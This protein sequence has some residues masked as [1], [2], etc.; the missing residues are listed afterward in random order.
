MSW[1]D[2][3][4]VYQED[5][6]PIHE[7]AAVEPRLDFYALTRE[8]LAGALADRFEASAYR[9]TQL[10][11]WVYK[12][13]VIDCGQMT[14]ITK[15]LR[16]ELPGAFSFEPAVIKQKLV[17][18][19]GSRKYLLEVRPGVQVETVLI[20]QPERTTL[21]VSSQYG[22]G[23][24]C[25]FCRTGTMGFLANLTTGD[26]LRQVNAVRDDHPGQEQLFGNIVFMGMGEPLHNINAVAGAVRILKDCHA[27][28]VGPR[29]IT[30]STVGLVPGIRKFIAAD[31]EVNLAVS[32]NATTDE[33]RERIMPVTKRY[34]I[35]QL[36]ACLREV[37]LKKRRKIT[38]EYVMLSDVNDTD[39]D[40]RRLPGLL[41]GLSV[42][43]NLIPYN[44]NAGLPFKSP[45][46]S[47]VL[48]WHESLNLSGLDTTVRWSR[49]LDINAACGQLAVKES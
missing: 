30:V 45:P 13:R 4:A 8:E 5:Q 28:G 24:A 27:I 47:R 10:F 41:H 20:R 44:E 35:A 21:C 25:A 46:R 40:L 36:L 17:S 6:G 3:S 42:K 33:V 16:D 15:A 2:S 38:I 32:L 43:I 19:D 37:P 29:R 1:N 12:K 31:L 22:C 39:A 26:I 7:A 23:M 9:A 48:Q 14:N 11:D 34:P 49:G 18:V